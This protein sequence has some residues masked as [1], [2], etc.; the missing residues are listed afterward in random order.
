[1]I[2]VDNCI[3]GEKHCVSLIDKD[4]ITLKQMFDMLD[5]D[6]DDREE[7]SSFLIFFKAM[8]KIYNTFLDMGIHRSE[9][10]SMSIIHNQFHI[11]MVDDE[12]VDIVKK[13]LN[14]KKFKMNGMPV[15]LSV[16]CNSNFI[17]VEVEH[18]E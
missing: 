1:M 13:R 6:I 7:S 17:I 12:Y 18:D 16:K 3:S 9:F 8:K 5:I 11:E 10:E 14:N 2:I 15:K 4:V